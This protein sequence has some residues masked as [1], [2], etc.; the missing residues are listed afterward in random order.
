[1]TRDADPRRSRARWRRAR[2]RPRDLAHRRRRSGRRRSG[3]R[4]FPDTGRAYLIG[5]TGPAGRRQEHAG[6]SAGRGVPRSRHETVGIIAVDPTSPFTGG[7]IL[8][9]R[10]RMQ[11]HASDDGRLHPQHG[12]ARP[13]GRPRPRHRRCGARAR[14]GRQATSS[15]SRPSASGRTKSTSCAPPMSRVVILVPGHGRRRAGAQGR[16]HG[17]RRHL[18]RQ[19]GGSRRRRS[20]W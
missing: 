10:M 19:Q 7:A 3:P 13:P 15:S 9:D 8:G 18:R 5:V 16:H 11:A 14:R 12:D 2:H 20:A 1:M 17:D 6:R 4:L